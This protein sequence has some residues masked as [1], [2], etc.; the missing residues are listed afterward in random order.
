MFVTGIFLLLVETTCG[1]NIDINF[2]IVYSREDALKNNNAYFGYTVLLHREPFQ[3]RSCINSDKCE[4]IVPL[5][6]GIKPYI[7][8]IKLNISIKMQ[9]GWFGSAM[10]VT[11]DSLLV[12]CAPRTIVTILDPIWNDNF[13]TMQGVCY[14]G[15]ITWN[16]LLM[17]DDFSYHD[18]KSPFWYNPL[19]GFSVQFSAKR[20]SYLLLMGDPKRE[21]YGTV[22]IMTLSNTTVRSIAVEF[23]L[24]DDTAQFGYSVDFGYFFKRDQ[25]LYVS[26]APGWRYVG[27]V[28]IINLESNV[29]VIAQLHGTDIGEYFGASLAVGDLNNDGLDDLLVGAPYWGEDN[30]KVY[31]YFGTSK[32]QF[33]IAV[34]LK[35]IADGGHFGYTIACGDL[36][37]DGFDDIIVGAPWEE[38]GVIYIYNGDSDLKNTNLQ[39]SQRIEGAKLPQLNFPL[40][41]QRFGFSLS[42]PVDID[43]N[44]YQDIAVGAYKSEH[45]VILRSKPVVKTELVIQTVPNILQRDARQF[46]I[47]ICL[48]YTSHNTQ[49][50]QNFKITVTIDERYQ[51]TIEKILELKSFNLTSNKCLSVPINISTN[52][53]DFIQPISIFA[54]HDFIYDNTPSEFCKFCPI[55]RRNNKLQI[56]QALLPF[57]I[58]CGEDRICNSSISATATFHNV[59]YGNVWVIGSTDISLEINLKNHGEP[60]YLT[61]LEFTFPKGVVLRSILTSCQ[62]DTS[63]ENLLIICDMG[64]LILN[65]EEKNIK[66]DLDMRRLINGSLYDRELDFY[67]AIKTHSINRGTTYIVKTLN[68][69]SEVSAT[70]HGKAKEEAYY[71]TAL[72]EGASNIS[73]QHTYQVYKLG[74][75]P[76]ENAQLIVKVPFAIKDS[77]TLVHIY[78]SQLYTSGEIVECSSENILLDTQL[79]KVQGEPSSDQSNMTLFSN[80]K[81]QTGAR[82]IEKRSLEKSVPLLYDGKNN[83]TPQSLNE[84]W[85]NNIIYMNCSTPDVNCATITCDLNALKTLQNIGK[86]E[87]KLLL[88]VDKFKDNFKNNKAVLKF[89]TEASVEIIE[90]AVRIHINGTRSKMEIATMFYNSPKVEELQLWIILISVLVGLLFLLIF[91][92]ILSKLGFFKR[93]SKQN[94]TVAEVSTMK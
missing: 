24:S 89:S 65:G 51:R 14:L 93:K 10:S 84:S 43:G 34:T 59:R 57:K 23:P 15:K 18:F 71:F 16:E 87:I 19:H 9:H 28:G 27:L 7:N 80:I 12:V 50:T 69:V 11:N 52:I 66:L 88:N 74:P 21:N 8:Q 41:I 81:L 78:E 47:Q 39:V 55:E 31:A 85:S 20:K 5:Y 54:K 79:V 63:K 35:G 44:G 37:A 3:D 48:K 70:L 2:P 49:S 67:V 94:L 17:D 60:A 30:G 64:N 91:A 33:E 86:M 76:L 83:K 62:E 56:A 1:Y 36:D 6:L 90:P 53:R 92:A 32:G 77:K 73:F 13:D 25:L 45:A 61:T 75:S 82:A 29:S 42:K 68:L 72:D 38:S 40:K 58:D 4:K 22:E 46:L 26:G